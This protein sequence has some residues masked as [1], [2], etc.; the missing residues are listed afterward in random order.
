MRHLLELHLTS[1][2]LYDG[3]LFLDLTRLQ[4]I[5][6]NYVLILCRTLRGIFI[7]VYFYYYY[8]Y[9]FFFLTSPIIRDY[10]VIMSKSSHQRCSVKEGVLRNFAKFTENTCAKAPFVIKLQPSARNFIKKE[11]LA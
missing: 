3:C 7:T 8:Y 5:I 11:T 9:Y 1:E 10:H 4:L 6:C 2:R